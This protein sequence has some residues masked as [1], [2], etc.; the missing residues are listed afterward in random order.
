MAEMRP[1]PVNL[2]A[3]RSVLGSCV[4]SHA[5]LDSAVVEDLTPDD[6]SVSDHRRIFAAILEMH[7]KKVP[8]DFISLAEYLG[9]GQR[10]FALI[11]DLV[12][13]AVVHHS[14]VRHHVRI[15]REKSKLRALL[16]LADWIEQ[17][18]IEPCADPEQIAKLV[19][20]KLEPLSVSS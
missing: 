4:E 13:G 18:A 5:L 10:E 12:S 1:V 7:S 16:R 6:F 15:V 14:H 8:V 19:C 20:E 9:N 3:E 11:A 17:A 2:A